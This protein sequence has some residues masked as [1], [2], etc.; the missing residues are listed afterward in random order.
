MKNFRHTPEKHAFCGL[1]S[2]NIVRTMCA[3]KPVD[4]RDKT[5]REKNIEE[6]PRNGCLVN[7]QTGDD[8]WKREKEYPVKIVKKT[9]FDLQAGV[10]LIHLILQQLLFH[11]VKRGHLKAPLLHVLPAVFRT[12]G[13]FAEGPWQAFHTKMTDGDSVLIMA[14]STGRWGLT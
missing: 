8:E 13:R 7:G 4:D 14:F 5:D 11:V 1:F 12:A 2:P 10:E 6:K 3:V 9:M